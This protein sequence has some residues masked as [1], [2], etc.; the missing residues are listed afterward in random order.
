MVNPRPLTREERE[1]LGEAL[2]QLTLEELTELYRNAWDDVDKNAYCYICKRRFKNRHGLSIH[3]SRTHPFEFICLRIHDF[4]I[5][6]RLGILKDYSGNVTL[7]VRCSKC[8]RILGYYKGET[9]W[10]EGLWKPSE[11]W[12]VCSGCRGGEK[13]AD[14][15]RR[16]GRRIR[17][18]CEGEGVYYLQII[19]IA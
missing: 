19:E 13:G 8:G 11:A 10:I 2:K 18:N 17:R 14:S 12:I 15:R 6:K 1:Q 9:F 3:S 16:S 7:E 4:F 5:A